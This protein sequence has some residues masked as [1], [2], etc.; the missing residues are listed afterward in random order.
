MLRLEKEMA[1]HS[2]ILAWKIPWAEVPGRLQSMGSHRV[3]YDWVTFT[4]FM[5]RWQYFGSIG[6]KKNV[7]NSYFTLF[8]M[9]KVRL[10][11]CLYY[12][13]VSRD[14]S[15]RQCSTKLCGSVV[16][17]FTAQI[18][19]FSVFS[20]FY[21]DQRGSVITLKQVIIHL[22]LFCCL[23]YRVIIT[24]FLNSLYMCQYTVLVFF[25]HGKTNTV[26]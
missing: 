18:Y 6:L 23:A 7:L 12:M 1:T 16:S 10:L 4:H 5:L 9:F 15:V 2:S 17:S 20:V 14:T 11:E 22:C 25:F 8:Y 26:L 13:C 3:R 21:V 24:I 19:S